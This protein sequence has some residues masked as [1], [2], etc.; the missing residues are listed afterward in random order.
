MV[1]G[2]WLKK[3]LGWFVVGVGLVAVLF[4]CLFCL[5]ICNVTEEYA[6]TAQIDAFKYELCTYCIIFLVKICLDDCAC[7]YLYS[8][9]KS[10]IALVAKF[11]YARLCDN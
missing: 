6:F 5:F 11:S 8:V 3:I 2:H 9:T 7:F 1:L 4:V 10:Y